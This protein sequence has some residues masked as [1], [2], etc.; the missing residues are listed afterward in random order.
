MTE[1]HA[2]QTMARTW[3]ATA[4]IPAAGWTQITDGSEPDDDLLTLRCWSQ[5]ISLPA[6]VRVRAGRSQSIVTWL[7]AGYQVSSY[8]GSALGPGV[9]CVA[10]QE[11]IEAGTRLTCIA[12]HYVF[13]AGEESVV[14]TVDPTLLEMFALLFVGLHQLIGTLEVRRPDGTDFRSL[15]VPGYSVA[16]ADIWGGE[17]DTTR[18]G[19]DHR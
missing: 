9:Q 12:V 3:V 2:P 19:G 13:V 7:T 1:T 16:A 11:G 8:D 18:D 17:P 6:Y 15:P 10:E 4:A 5:E 14:V